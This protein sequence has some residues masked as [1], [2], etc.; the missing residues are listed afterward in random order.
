MNVSIR[1]SRSLDIPT[2]SGLAAV[3][4][5]ERSD[6]VVAV[7]AATAT[8]AARMPRSLVSSA[9]TPSFLLFRGGRSVRQVQ[10]HQHDGAVDGAEPVRRVLGRHDEVA[11]GPLAR[12]AAFNA[13]AGEVRAVAC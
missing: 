1:A 7:S 3:G 2:S 13:L 5:L 11:L 8:A 10:R 6:V 9:I 4:S 12:P